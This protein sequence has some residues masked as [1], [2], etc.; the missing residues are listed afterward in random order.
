M[1]LLKCV[2]NLMMES[3]RD[4]SRTRHQ[5]SRIKR[6]LLYHH[7]S[8]KHT[9]ILFESLVGN[10]MGGGGATVLKSTAESQ[11]FKAS[12]PLQFSKYVNCGVMYGLHHHIAPLR[13]CWLYKNKSFLVGE[14]IVHA[15]FHLYI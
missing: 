1:L 10:C 15:I 14:G 11:C 2:R 3:R 7:D 5:V 4:V 9:F 12:A 8:T 6:V 13:C